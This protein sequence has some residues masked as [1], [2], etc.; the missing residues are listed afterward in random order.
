MIDNINVLLFDDIKDELIN[1][2]PLIT[3]VIIDRCFEEIGSDVFPYRLLIE[4]VG[5]NIVKVTPESSYNAPDFWEDVIVDI[6]LM[7]IISLLTS[8]QKLIDLA[9]E[10]SEDNPKI[11]LEE[12]GQFFSFT[13]RLSG[14]TF[15]DIFSKL[16]MMYCDFEVLDRFTHAESR[17]NFI[18]GY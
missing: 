15:G 17:Q 10:Y 14:L 11:L 1:N 13:M 3:P 8:V 9:K 18:N 4:R 2:L 12:D 6:S 5:N 16:E 7:E